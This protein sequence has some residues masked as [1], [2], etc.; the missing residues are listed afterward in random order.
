M[1]FIELLWILFTEILNVQKVSTSFYSKI[2]ESKVMHTEKLLKIATCKI[3]SCLMYLNT[4]GLWK[5]KN[6]NNFIEEQNSLKLNEVTI[7]M[8]MQIRYIKVKIIS[9]TF[10]DSSNFLS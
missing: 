6:G 7:F 4:V 2:K 8:L 9:S 3:M 1:S 5:Q 10:S